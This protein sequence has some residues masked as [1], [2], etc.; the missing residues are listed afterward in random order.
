M[1]NKI[2]ILN[3]VSS[4]GKSSILKAFQEF[5]SDCYYGI[6]MDRINDILPQ[7][8]RVYDQYEALS[9]ENRKGFYYN[10]EKQKFELGEYAK[11]MSEDFWHIIKSL[12]NRKRNIIIDTVSFGLKEF[13]FAGEILDLDKNDVYLVRVTC[14]INELRKREQNR[15]DRPVG[16]AEKQIPMIDTKY[17]DLVLNSTDGNLQ[18][19]TKQLTDFIKNNKPLALKNLL[20]TADK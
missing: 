20:N 18:S 16:S 2:I 17:N 13:I 5:S 19:L 3:G 9:E 8:Y 11:N 7:K 10:K 6:R 1:K 12:A 14:N 4:S 15:G